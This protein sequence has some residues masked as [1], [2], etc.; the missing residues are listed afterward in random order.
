[1][2]WFDLKYKALIQLSFKNPVILQDFFLHIIFRT[3]TK[4]KH[5]IHLILYNYII[6]IL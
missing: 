3:P 6:T 5:Q 2:V 1:M 4:I